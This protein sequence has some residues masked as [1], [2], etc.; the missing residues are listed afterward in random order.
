MAYLWDGLS[1]R[2]LSLFLGILV[3]TVI[4]SLAALF[5]FLTFG[6]MKNVFVLLEHPWNLILEY[7]I[8][9]LFQ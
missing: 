1:K 2:T 9:K 5:F 3:A 6:L 4:K 8:W 7:E